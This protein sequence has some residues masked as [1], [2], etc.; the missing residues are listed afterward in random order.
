MAYVSQD[1]KKA[2]APIVKTLLKQFGLKGSLSVRHHSTLVLTIASGS[3]DFIGE[4]NGARLARSEREGCEYYPADGYVD[5]NCYHL[6]SSYS[7]KALN[8][9]EKLESALKGEGWFDKSDLM[10]DYF[11]VK[12]YVDIK[13]GRYNKPYVLN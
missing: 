6:E 1:D 8:A 3:I 2:I 7:G 12:H 11:H 4:A 10:T 9:L 5:V 13:V